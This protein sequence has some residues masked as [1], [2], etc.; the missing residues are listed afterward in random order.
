MQVEKTNVQS[1]INKAKSLLERIF[2]N[3]PSLDKNDFIC[4]NEENNLLY[5]E[6][7]K[8]MLLL[9][10]SDSEIKK[11]NN[12]HIDTTSLIINMINENF[13]VDNIQDEIEEIISRVKDTKA[14]IFK[15]ELLEIITNLEKNSVLSTDNVKNNEENYSL[16]VSS[17][18]KL[19]EILIKLNKIVSDS[20]IKKCEKCEKCE[21]V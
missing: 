4:S 14:G 17:A 2:Q 18:M 21:N 10:K 19:I 6:M 20:L 8:N 3:Y 1:S 5:E 15:F 7:V 9:V 13:I 12:G 11:D 16:I